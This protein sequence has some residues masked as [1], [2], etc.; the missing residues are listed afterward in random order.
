FQSLAAVS[1][2]SLLTVCS[3][4]A[5]MVAHFDFEE[6]TGTSTSSS[7][8]G[9]PAGTLNTGSSWAPG[10][11]P[12]ST[13]SVLVDG[14][15]AGVNVGATTI[16]NN[17]A[18]FSVS[19]WIKPTV[20]PGAGTDA[21]TFFW[22]GTTAASG[23]ARFVMQLLDGGDIRVGG[24]RLGANGFT[25]VSTNNGTTNGTV[26]DPITVGQT[27]HVAATADYSTGLVTVYVNG[28]QVASANLSSG[29]TTGNSEN[30]P[31]GYIV[32][33][34]ANGPGTGERFNGNIDNTRVFN[35]VLTPS[36]VA[37]LAVP[38]PTLGI[39]AGVGSLLWV[40][41]LRRRTI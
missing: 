38:E 3:A 37:A 32:R 39:L 14:A 30:N 5:A 17:L 21:D 29:W 12:N 7:V 19:T 20:L 41:G 11:A 31:E 6:G 15:S 2:L 35:T 24:R 22:L 18:G 16:W 27:Y 1:T 26:N 25:T 8:A 28:A 4:N 34:G 36:E 9:P 23:N 10:I 13:A 40:F 33:F